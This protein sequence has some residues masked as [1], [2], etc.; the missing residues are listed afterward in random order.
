MN[1]THNFTQSVI[2]IMFFSLNVQFPPSWNSFQI[3]EINQNLCQLHTSSLTAACGYWK[4]A[5]LLCQCGPGLWTHNLTPFD[6]LLAVV[7]LSVVGHIIM[8][9]STYGRSVQAL[10]VPSMM[11]NPA[12]S[13]ACV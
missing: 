1:A 7:K 8:E 3:P 9:R 5:L 11:S 4:F 2:Y 13:A 6:L 10:T 12:S